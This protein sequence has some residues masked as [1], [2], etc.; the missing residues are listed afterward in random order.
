MKQNL[1]PL[2]EFDLS[3]MAQTFNRLLLRW[4]KAG[5]LTFEWIEAIKARYPF[6]YYYKA[7]NMYCQYKDHKPDPRSQRAISSSC[8]TIFK[9]TM[10]MIIYH[11]LPQWYQLNYKI[12]DTKALMFKILDINKLDALHSAPT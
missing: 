9:P 2:P 3:K 10:Q 5:E 6:D 4:F 8:G 11:L 12:K 7:S 1:V